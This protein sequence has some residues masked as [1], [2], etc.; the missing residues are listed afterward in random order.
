MRRLSGWAELPGRNVRDRQ[1]A[2]HVFDR[3]DLRCWKS[4]N[5]TEIEIR[6]REKRD[7]VEARMSDW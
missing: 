2:F 6:D 1:A 7:A 4:S 5:V 3:R